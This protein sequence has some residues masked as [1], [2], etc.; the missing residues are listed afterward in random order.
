MKHIAT[1]AIFVLLLSCDPCPDCGK[2]IASEPTVEMIFIYQDSIDAIDEVLMDLDSLD[3]TFIS[4]NTL[5]ADF[6]DSLQALNDSIDLGLTEYVD[7][8]DAVLDTIPQIQMDSLFLETLKIED[9]ISTLSST[10]ATINSG[11]ILVNEIRFPE[12]NESLTYTDDDSSDVW[13]FPLSFEKR[14]AI[15]EVLIQD[16]TLVIELD[17]ETFTEVD[18]ERNVRIRA[19]NIQLID[20][21]GVD[22]VIVCEQNCVDGEASFT[23]YF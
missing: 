18:E 4:I 23:F 22:S 14:F 12:V 13:F 5:L 11:N 10:R 2:P 21:T 15:Y 16:E 3:S 19:E 20:T 8:R 6:R 17:Y 1:L 7:E 9:S